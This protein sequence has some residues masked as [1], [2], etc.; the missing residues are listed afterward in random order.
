MRAYCEFC[1]PDGA[2]WFSLADCTTREV[3]AFVVTGPNPSVPRL[4]PPNFEYYID[5]LC[6]PT[7]APWQYTAGNN[8]V[9]AIVKVTK[10]SDSVA[11]LTFNLAYNGNYP[12][13]ETVTIRYGWGAA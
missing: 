1:G 12:A 10:T 4:G 8:N 9:S 6:P 5:F 3:G 2:V 11:R 7:T 13:G